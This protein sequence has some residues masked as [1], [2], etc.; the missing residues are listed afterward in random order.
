MSKGKEQ[1]SPPLNLMDA[2]LYIV[3]GSAMV[4]ISFTFLLWLRF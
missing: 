2:L 1:T 3:A 4:F